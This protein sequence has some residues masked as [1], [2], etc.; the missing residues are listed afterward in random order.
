[1]QD[2][3]AIIVGITRYPHF[4]PL[5]APERDARAFY[6]WVRSPNGGDVPEGN[7]TLI[8][9]SLYPEETNPTETQVDAAFRKLFVQAQKQGGVTGRRLYLFFAGHGFAQELTEAS[10]L[11]A[12][13]DQYSYLHIPGRRYAEFFRAAAFFQELVLFADCC[14]NHAPRAPPKS[15]PFEPEF[16]AGARDVKYL[17]AYA[18]QWSMAALEGPSSGFVQ[19]VFTQ[20]LLQGLRN[21]QDA[22]GRVTSES[23]RDFLLNVPS[24]LNYRD[25]QKPE[26]V[27]GGTLQFGVDRPLQRF[28]VHFHLQTPGAALPIKLRDSR[29]QVVSAQLLPQGPATFGTH[30]PRGLYLAMAGSS[31]SEF[32]VAGTSEV[33]HVHL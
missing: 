26:L 2:D 28:P 11:M 21:A 12:N 29:M 5:D 17:Y 13:A 19:G 4:S 31:D 22:A 10:L 6:D 24:L 32:E 14:R 3:Y 15:P 1:M 16:N 7:I 30:L 9:S 18:T 33:K 20:A 27:L 8:C 25:Q 23:L